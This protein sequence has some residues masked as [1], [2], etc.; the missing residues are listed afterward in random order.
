M[1]G[2]SLND[3]DLATFLRTCVERGL[4]ESAT[5]DEIDQILRREIAGDEKGGTPGDRVELHSRGYEP[6]LL[7]TVPDPELTFETLV[8]CKSNAFAVE[9]A[10]VVAADGASRT[11]YNPLYIYSDVGL[12]KTHLLSC[13]ANASPNRRPLLINASDIEFEYERAKRVGRRAELRRWLISAAPLLIDDIQLCEGHEDSQRELFAVVNHMIRNHRSVVITS[14]VPPTRLGG[15]ESRLLSRLG[16]GVIVALHIGDKSERMEILRQY[17]GL[18][19]LPDYVIDFLAEQI[20]DSVRRLKGAATQLLALRERLGVPIELE[21]ARSVLST[22]VEITKQGN[23]TL[24]TPTSS[25]GVA[26]IGHGVPQTERFKEMLAEA[27]NEEER[28]LALQIAL[29]ERLRQLNKANGDPKVIEKFERA[30]DLLREGRT[31][32]AIKHIGTL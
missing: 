11:A 7:E 9:V 1:T 29:G 6:A 13:I 28:S 17:V 15:V 8:P 32:E 27:E 26:P 14:D 22:P 25:G 31:E 18:H 4:L 23:F 3:F 20:S 19:P 10:R 24:K 16:G 2:K 5:A 30:L 12:G 21:L